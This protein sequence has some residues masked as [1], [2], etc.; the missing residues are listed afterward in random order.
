MPNPYLPDSFNPE[1]Y[2]LTLFKPDMVLTHE[3]LNTLFGFLMQQ[4]T[5]TR[6]NLI[7]VGVACGLEVSV[8]R[9]T[10]RISKGTGV[11]TEGDLISFPNAREYLYYAPYI[12]SEHAPYLPFRSAKGLTFWE[13]FP[14][15]QQTQDTQLL[16]D[17]FMEDKVV[18]LYLES[19]KE[20][21]DR[22]SGIDCDN[23]GDQFRNRLHVLVVRRNDA[24]KLIT[25]EHLQASSACTRL[26]ALFTR[27]VMVDSRKYDL[28]FKS[29]QAF[30]LH[31][32]EEFS[33]VLR[34]SFTTVSEVLQ[35]TY[36]NNSPVD[37]WINTIET[38]VKLNL[39]TPNIQYLY[40]WFKDLYD[41]YEEFRKQ[42]CCWLV[43]CNPQASWFPKH[44]LLGEVFPAS[45]K[46]YY[47]H[48][49]IKSP[50]VLDCNNGR[51]K[52]IWLYQRIGKLI[53]GFEIPKRT[54]GIPM[55]PTFPFPTRDVNFFRNTLVP[56]ITPSQDRTALLGDR[57][58]PFYYDAET[59]NFWNYELTKRCRQNDLL[60]FN[61]P[62]KPS[63]FVQDPFKYDID[64]LSFY[65]IEGILG[66][67]VPVVLRTL[68]ALKRRHNIAFKIIA[69]NVDADK[70]GLSDFDRFSIRH[71]G[72]E[73]LAGVYRGATFILAYRNVSSG[74]KGGAQMVVADFCLPYLCCEPETKK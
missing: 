30:I 19:K 72:S 51:T 11:T 41:A 43:A 25:K 29:F 58:I 3:Q 1:D 6:T 16:T 31:R 39:N 74:V 48:Y 27:R 66:G 35:H 54:A 69:L 59:R 52:A 17:N 55:R 22:C 47:R 14:G 20:S 23:Q 9:Q 46:P 36:P 5:L 10:I 12:L 73:H 33:K 63:A 50:A 53:T 49:F 61:L 26:S 45:C 38:Q 42:T 32:M 68:Q 24:A 4:D 18:L 44:L 64:K 7:G 57:A 71:S 15:P 62:D 28:S 13:L 40:D 65:R 34:K 21:A 37:Q 60:S 2:G 56:K 8:F 67:S 70:S